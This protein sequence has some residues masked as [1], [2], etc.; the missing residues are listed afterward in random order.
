MFLRFTSRALFI[1]A[2][3]PAFAVRR[4]F[5]VSPFSRRA[6]RAETAWDQ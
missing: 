3:L 4:L 5:G 6:H 2:Y 1:G